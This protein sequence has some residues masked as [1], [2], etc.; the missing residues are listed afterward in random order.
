MNAFLRAALLIILVHPSLPAH[1]AGG[2]RA[3]ERRSKLEMI[4][5]SQDTR[6]IHDGTLLHLLTDRDESVRKAAVHAFGSIQDTSVIQLL[7][8]RL[9][10]DQSQRVQSEAAF[11]IGQ[12]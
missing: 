8:D 12:T 3:E 11:A 7:V 6:T 5:R 1:P 4:L 9:A 10:N 2:E